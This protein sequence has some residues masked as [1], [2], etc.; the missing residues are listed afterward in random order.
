MI[1]LAGTPTA[2]EFS[3]TSVTTTELAPIFE[4]EPTVIFPKIFAPLPI[5]TFDLIVGCRFPLL[6][7]TPPKLHP[8]RLKHHLL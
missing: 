1:I 4:L 3:G 6:R 5:T 7:L 8:D 2:V